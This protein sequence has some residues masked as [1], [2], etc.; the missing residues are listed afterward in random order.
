MD[1]KREKLKGQFSNHVA[2]YKRAV[3]KAQSRKNIFLRALYGLR[4]F[5]FSY[6]LYNVSKWSIGLPGNVRGKLFWGR[7]MMWPARDTG[8]HVLSMYGISPH[9]SERK[10]S[11]WLMQHLN[12][13]DVL[14]DVG[15]HLGYY[16]ALCEELTSKGEVHAFEANHVLCGYLARNFPVSR[17]VHIVCSAVADTNQEVDFYN[18]SHSADS[19]V[20]SRFSLSKEHHIS[21]KVSAVTLDEYVKAGNRAPTVIKLDIEGGEYDAI[22]GAT[23]LIMKHKPRI[24]MEVWSGE[25]GSRYSQPAVRKL[26]ELGYR[27]FSLE[28]DGSISDEHIGDPVGSLATHAPHARDNFLFQAI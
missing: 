25:M 16:T 19:S 7:K 21:T 22:V 4:T 9:A 10:L 26:V 23:N 18:T 24:V 20:G 6:L 17:R 3:G 1:T 5:G 28:H 2:R 8:A 15:A 13:H 27:A 12:E 14:Y 11:L